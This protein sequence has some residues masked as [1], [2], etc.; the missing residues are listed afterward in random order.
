MKYIVQILEIENVTHDVKG[1]VARNLKGIVLFP[2]RPHKCPS[3]RKAGKK[4]EGLSL[5]HL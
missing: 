4:S 1:F 3:I 2:V 5:S